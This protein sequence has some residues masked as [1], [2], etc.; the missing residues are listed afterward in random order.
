MGLSQI[1]P[2]TGKWLTRGTGIEDY[3]PSMLAV[4]EINLHMGARYLADQLRRYGGSRDLALIA[5]NAGPGR[6][7]RWKSELGYGGDPDAFREKIPFD[8]TR[9]Y[10]M[11][12][13]RNAAVYRR[14]YG[15]PR[16]PGLPSE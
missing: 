12:V 8:E 5:Y 13:L 14:L 16:G 1:M 10:V 11:V 3:D 4:A 2:S 9:E 7:D 6:A 15:G